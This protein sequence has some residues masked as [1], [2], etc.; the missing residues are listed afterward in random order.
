SASTTATTAPPTAANA[1]TSTT[2][3]CS[4]SSSDALHDARPR[5]KQYTEVAEV[6]QRNT[7]GKRRVQR[8]GLDA[9]RLERRVRRLSFPHSP[10]VL[11]VLFATFALNSLLLR[12]P[13]CSLH[14]LCVRLW[15][16]THGLRRRGIR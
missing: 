8:V 2:S 12:L 6:A 1:T 9:P 7:E 14:D 10:P 16:P 13:L 3:C 11:F 5:R 4:S 15:G